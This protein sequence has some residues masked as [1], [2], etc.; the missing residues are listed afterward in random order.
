MKIELKDG[1]WALARSK[2]GPREASSG[3]SNSLRQ[4]NFHINLIGSRLWQEFLSKSLILTIDGGRGTH[5]IGRGFSRK[6][7]AEPRG[8]NRFQFAALTTVLLLL[9]V[10]LAGAQAPTGG[11]R[12]RITDPSGA[13]IPQARVSATR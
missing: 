5:V 11:L 10:S 8:S 3:I 2:E 4:K 13:V 12:G 6:R 9:M 7:N 1:S